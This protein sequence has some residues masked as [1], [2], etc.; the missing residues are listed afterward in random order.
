MKK[1]LFLSLR[2]EVKLAASYYANI[3]VEGEEKQL[4]F[5][6]L[7]Y[8]RLRKRHKFILVWVYMKNTTRN[9][10]LVLSLLVLH[11]LLLIHFLPHP[12]Y[13]ISWEWKI[14][15]R[16]KISEYVS[17]W[18]SR[19]FMYYKANWAF[20]KGTSLTCFYFLNFLN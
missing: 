17:K 10:F 6:I 9:S 2:Y 4:I 7:I 1:N 8:F 18:K 14:R 11:L 20:C 3:F 16:R 13:S 19:C 15:A 12:L 5:I